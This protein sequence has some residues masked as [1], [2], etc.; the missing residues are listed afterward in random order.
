MSEVR[1]TIGQIKCPI[2]GDVAEVRKNKRSKLYYVGVAGM[3]T[4]NNQAGQNWILSNMKAFDSSEREKVNSEPV[5]YGRRQT[6]TEDEEST[7][8]L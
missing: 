8:M 6:H 1:E 4:P 3:I 2:G 5:E 7:W